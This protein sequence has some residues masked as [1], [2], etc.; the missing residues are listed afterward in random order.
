MVDQL[1][2]VELVLHKVITSHTKSTAGEV[3][4]DVTCS[5]TQPLLYALRELDKDIKVQFALI[6]FP[7]KQKSNYESQ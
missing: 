1:P 4:M 3:H 7:T 6:I 5:A 2:L